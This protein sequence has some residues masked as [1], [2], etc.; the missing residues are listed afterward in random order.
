MPATFHGTAETGLWAEMQLGSRLDF[1][2]DF[3]DALD[4]G[5]AIASAVWTA[6]TGITLTGQAHDD[7]RATVWIEGGAANT[8]YTV[9]AA[10]TTAV[11]RVHAQAFRLRVTDAA[12]AGATYRSVFPSLAAAVSDLRRDRLMT[13][14]AGL[15][16]DAG[17]TDDYLID[18][19]AAAEA[20]AQRALRVFL[21][22]REV[23]PFDA[24]QAEEDALVADGAVVHREA[25]YDYDPQ[26]WRDNRWGMLE[27]RQR[28]ASVV[29]SLTFAY[30]SPGQTLWTVPADWIRLDPK[31]ARVQIVPT[32]SS[33]MLPLNSMLLSWVSGGRSVPFM[34]QA[35]YRAGLADAARDWP[36]LLGVIKQMA[37]ASIIEDRFMPASGSTSA[38]GISQS[39]SWDMDKAKDAIEAKL[40]RLRSAIRGIE[41]FA[42]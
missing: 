10:V 39:L 15:L 30:P 41:M 5:D 21:T 37:V 1:T 12:T 42:A 11:G 20:T 27:L 22:P 4:P 13:V 18:K 2:L 6:T 29:H 38:D 3:T 14:A 26:M 17:V 36:D 7:T 19:L 40:K 23:I 28:P 34:L 35:R 33:N 32:Q 24:S 9:R 25:G 31:P 16:P 8:W